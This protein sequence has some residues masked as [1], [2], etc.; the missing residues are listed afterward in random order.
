MKQIVCGVVLVVVSM[1][2][3]I[4]SARA[5]SV[6]LPP[7]RPPAVPLLTVDPYFSVWS[8]N[9][10]LTD[11]DTQHW[12]GKPHTMLSL[13]RIDDKPFRLA[14]AQPKDVPA[15]EQT[16]VRYCRRARSTRSAAAVCG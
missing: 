6:E 10:R 8:F 9:D 4:R 1:A 2:G 11:A 13:V 16:K 7:L 15:L 12:T 5:G 14:G 3:S